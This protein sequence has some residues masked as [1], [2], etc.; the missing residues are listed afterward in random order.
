MTAK[1]LS[2]LSKSEQ[3][4]R[5]QQDI[6]AFLKRGGAINA[7]EYGPDLHRASPKARPWDSALGG[8]HGL[9]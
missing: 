4:Q 5:L 9:A 8:V 7:L 1:K 2:Q 6:A 3:Q